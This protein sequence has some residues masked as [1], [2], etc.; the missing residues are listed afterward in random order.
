MNY[1]SD[2]LIIDKCKFYSKIYIFNKGLSSKDF[3]YLIKL[4]KILIKQKIIIYIRSS[5]KFC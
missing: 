1:L 4:D 2:V 3:K 5:F